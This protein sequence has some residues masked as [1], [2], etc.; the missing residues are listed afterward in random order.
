M[1]ADDTAVLRRLL[2]VALAAA[3]E[4]RSDRV[5][6]LVVD[7]ARDL[8]GARYG[9]IGV[10]DGAGGFAT[11]LTAGIDA[12]TWK[13]IGALPRQHGLLGILLRNPATIRVEDIR[14]DPRFAGWPAAHPEM[15]A[16]LGVPIVAGGEI[17][18]EL[19]LT[20]REDGS[21]FTLADQ[22]LVETLAAHAALALANA[23]RLER[24]REL[25][26]AQERTRLARDLH[27]SLTQTVFGLTLAAESA[28][29]LA[30]DVDPRLATQIARLRALSAAARDDMRVLV[31]T[32]R[33]VDVDREGLAAAL[34]KRVELIGRVHDVPVEVEVDGDPQLSPTVAR[35]LLYV[36]NEALT[37]ALRHG[38]ATRVEVRLS[39]EDGT[40]RLCVDDDGRGFDLAAT[41][42]SSRRLGLTSMRERADAVGGTFRIRTAPGTGTRV[43]VEVGRG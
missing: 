15:S 10:P 9:A 42:R 13:A 2:D 39:E 26:V 14:A 34:R 43:C 8:V 40:V 38:A 33:P 32:L 3:A 37:N 25:A 7:A 17:L 31:D 36:A 24:T 19:Y 22:R 23:Q 6:R 18:A 41:R 35:E 4:R 11:F 5:L 16:F 30:G 29:Q 21:M 12:A 27:D 20:D 1:G 28:A